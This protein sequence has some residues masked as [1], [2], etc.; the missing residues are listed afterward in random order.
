MSS[1][2][3]ARSARKH[4]AQGVSKIRRASMELSCRHSLRGLIRGSYVEGCAASCDFLLHSLQLLH[5]RCAP[6]A[7]GHRLKSETKFHHVNGSCP[8]GGSRLGEHSIGLGFAKRA[9]RHFRTI[10]RGIHASG[11]SR[12][13]SRGRPGGP[14]CRRSVEY[15]CWKGRPRGDRWDRCSPRGQ[16]R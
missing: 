8:N 12:T 16:C 6:L 9:K 14:S 4:N 10:W 15:P 13:A 5:P 11:A 3:C 2:S 1:I 7:R